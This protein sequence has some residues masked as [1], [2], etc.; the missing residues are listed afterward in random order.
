MSN[1]QERW[2]ANIDADTKKMLDEK[3]DYGEASEI[4]REV[5]QSIAYGSGWDEATLLDRQI[6]Q[7]RQEVR[8][9][10]DE[11]RSI[12]GAIETAEEELRE[13][14]RE[15]EEVQ[16]KQEQFE[17]ALWSFEQSFRSGEMGHINSS[18]P[19]VESFADE[20]GKD[21]DEFVQLLRERNPDVPD[22]AFEPF[23]T[24]KFRYDGVS[25]E[26]VNTPVEERDGTN[27][28]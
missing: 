19:R 26:K 22:Y 28:D 5:A 12:N 10:R 9:L 18:H 25:S 7:K 17:G 21:P 15:R 11:R 3:L 20:F 14:E 24:A 27:E 23:R 16:T 1:D 2:G 6:E 8:T 13:L 4:I